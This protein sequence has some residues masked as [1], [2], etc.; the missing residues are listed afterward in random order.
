MLVTVRGKIKIII[1][2]VFA[3]AFA[4]NKRRDRQ[5]D[6]GADR[7]QSDAKRFLLWTRTV[8]LPDAMEHCGNVGTAITKFRFPGKSETVRT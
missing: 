3:F 1:I 4:L 6:R 2:I 7:H 5:T 8:K